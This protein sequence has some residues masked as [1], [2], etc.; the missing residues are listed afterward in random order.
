MCAGVVQHW[1]PRFRNPLFCMVVRLLRDG[2]LA[3]GPDCD[4]MLNFC[5]DDGGAPAPAPAQQRAGRAAGA[6]GDQPESSAAAAGR[7]GRPPAPAEVGSPKPPQPAHAA[8][9]QVE[10]SLCVHA[11]AQRPRRMHVVL[12]C[13]LER[14]CMVL[15]I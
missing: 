4:G 6:G 7:A 11:A 1:Y 13:A 12:G 2:Q 15:R 5:D 9:L 8:Q 3:L 10:G 14:R